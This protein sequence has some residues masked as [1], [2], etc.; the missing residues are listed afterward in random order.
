MSDTAINNMYHGF[1]MLD[2]GNDPNHK[3]ISPGDVRVFRDEDGVSY[4]STWP[5][6]KVL[7]GMN[8]T[9]KSIMSSA[10]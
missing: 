10:H 1:I 3:L 2:K 6:S 8:P 5:K 4:P 9:G 7:K